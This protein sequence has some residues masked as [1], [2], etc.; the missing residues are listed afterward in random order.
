MGEVD[1]VG[2]HGSNGYTGMLEGGSTPG[3]GTSPQFLP[4][5]STPLLGKNNS[6]Q[7]SSGPAH[8]G[9]HRPSPPRSNGTASLHYVPNVVNT[10]WHQ[11]SDFRLSTPQRRILKASVAYLFACLVS[12]TPWFKP[13][14]GASGHL[15]A[16]SAV[17]FNPAKS[18]GGMVDAATAGL[19]AIL[20]GV[21]VSVAS[22][23]S[24]IWFNQR[25]LYI[26]GHVASVVVFGGGSTFIVAYAKAYYNRPTVYVG[27]CLRSSDRTALLF[28]ILERQRRLI[29]RHVHILI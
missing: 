13:Y 16:S 27:K 28:S 19:C 11:W 29:F 22:M 15:A 18:L 9:R 26:W 25:N 6:Y 7:S 8:N 24:A 23:L 12:F 4:S 5:S 14:I 2:G 10:L 3:P 20:F 1:D 21:L 17:F